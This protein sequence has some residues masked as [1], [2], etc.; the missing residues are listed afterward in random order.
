MIEPV[1]VTDAALV[2]EAVALLLIVIAVVVG[3]LTVIVLLLPAAIDGYAQ[4]KTPLLMVQSP[5]AVQLKPVPVGS[6][7]VNP[8]L[9]AVAVP[10]FDTT[11]VN[12][13]VPPTARVP[14]SGVW[15]TLRAAAAGA[16]TTIDPASV[17]DAV[18]VEEA[19]ALLLMVIAVVVGE[20]MIAVLLAP[21]ATSP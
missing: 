3:E 13:A 2:D 8:T 15:A 4:F 7:E 5:V 12:V 14:L 16:L 10:V 21:A 19:V 1:S 20:L 6:V 18:L 17:T 9:V 11:M